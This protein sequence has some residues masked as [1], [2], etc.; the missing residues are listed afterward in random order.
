MGVL[1][2]LV[3]TLLFTNTPCTCV[4]AHKRAVSKNL[5]LGDDVSW[6]MKG[7]SNW[8]SYVPNNFCRLEIADDGII[9]CNFEL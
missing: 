2:P 6:G 7:K 1:A 9:R 4:R 3:P 5:I 8:K